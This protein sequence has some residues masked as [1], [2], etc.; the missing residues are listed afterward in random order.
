MNSVPHLELAI[1]RL[2]LHNLNRR[3]LRTVGPRY[4]ELDEARAQSDLAAKLGVPAEKIAKRVEQLHEF[5][6]MLGHRGCRLGIA[7]PEIT[8]MQARAV[9]EAAADAN[10]RSPAKAN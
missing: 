4:V 3:V 10:K 1:F 9:F 2:T 5:N 8:E 7:Y 6:P